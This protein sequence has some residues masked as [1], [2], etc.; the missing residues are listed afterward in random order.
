M[1]TI[2]FVAEYGRFESLA[3]VFR[4]SGHD[5]RGHREESL[6]RSVEPRFR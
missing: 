1:C 5:R 2:V 3:D 6:A 4:Q